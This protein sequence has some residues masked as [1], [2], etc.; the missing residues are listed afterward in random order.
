MT[1]DCVMEPVDVED[2]LN[3]AETSHELSLMS[4]DSQTCRRLEQDESQP[5]PNDLSRWLS[6]TFCLSLTMLDLSR[7][8]FKILPAWI[9]SH[10]TA[11]RVLN[12]SRNSLQSLPKEIQRLTELTKLIVLSNNIRPRLLP[13]D[14][15]AALPNLQLLDLRYNSKIKDAAREILASK[16]PDRVELLLT[17]NRTVSPEPKLS[18]GDRDATLLRSQLE[19]L[20]TPQLRKRLERTFSVGVDISKEEGHDRKVLM[21]NLLQC[22]EK[23]GP[24]VIRQERGIPCPPDVLKELETELQSLE[25]PHDRERPKIA[26]Q[27]YMIL[28]KPETNSGVGSRAKREAA[29]LKRYAKV[30]KLATKAIMEVDPEFADRFTALAVT[31]NFSGSPHID[32]LNKGPFYGIS[33]GTFKNGGKIC[34]ECSATIVAEVDTKGKFGKVDGRFPHWV[35]AYEGERYS[36]IYYV[37]SGDAI[38]QTTA[39][40]RPQGKEGQD[41]V[42]PESFVL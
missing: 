18:A 29:K 13:V 42:P 36:L 16:L 40:F 34:V 10:L 41:W 17:V 26:A 25:W 5:I 1:P 24:R 33:M 22:Y 31:H 30:W 14:E 19:P 28:Q 12:V 23:V 7:N 15:L 20:S 21:N 39:V 11:L 2:A 35:S 4:L 37:T 38:P 3:E 9:C 6:P 8:R 32:T 27:H